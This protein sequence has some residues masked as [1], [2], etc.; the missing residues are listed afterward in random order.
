MSLGRDCLKHPNS[1]GS[2]PR[3]RGMLRALQSS[4]LEAV[5]ESHLPL[6]LCGRDLARRNT[7]FH[8]EASNPPT[9]DVLLPST[10]STERQGLMGYIPPEAESYSCLISPLI[11]FNLASSETQKRWLSDQQAHHSI[12]TGQKSS[13]ARDLPLASSRVSGLQE[14]VTCLFF[15]QRLSESIIVW[16]VGRLLGFKAGSKGREQEG[17]AICC[18]CCRCCF[19]SW[20]KHNLLGWIWNRRHA[21]VSLSLSRL[22]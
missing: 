21:Q 8:L 1:R 14:R 12:I 6:L 11:S 3:C 17:G 5:L 20:L 16:T 2:H 10:T 13:T 18:C 4:A 9:K 19:K 15:C 7:A 22:R